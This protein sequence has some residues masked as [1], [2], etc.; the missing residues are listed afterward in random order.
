MKTDEYVRLSKYGAA[1]GLGMFVAGALG[2]VVGHAVFAEIP[3]SLGTLFVYL[4][5]F[6]LAGFFLSI[7]AGGILPLALE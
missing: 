2:E 5:G 6:G 7:M 1:V 3:A 4:L